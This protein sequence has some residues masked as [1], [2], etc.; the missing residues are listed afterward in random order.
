MTA[1]HIIV[2]D[3][4]LAG[5]VFPHPEL[6]VIETHCQPIARIAARINEA[7][8]TTASMSGAPSMRLSSARSPARVLSIFAHGVT[9]TSGPVDWAMQVGLEYIHR[10]NALEFGRSIRGCISDRI[11]VMCCNGARSDDARAACRALARGAGVQVFAATTVQNFSQLETRP[12]FAGYPLTSAHPRGGWINFGRWEG[13][14]LAFPP[15]G[16][17]GRVAFE[18]PL[19]EIHPSDDGGGGTVGDGIFCE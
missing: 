14:V 11:R 4:R 8:T 18:G 7:V 5:Q 9:V 2:H 13:T 6:C 12:S 3:T 15:S 10:N 17:E 19:P 1:D 16:G